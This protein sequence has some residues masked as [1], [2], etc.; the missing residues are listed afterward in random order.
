MAVIANVKNAVSLMRASKGQTMLTMFGIIVGIVSVVTIVSLGQGIRNQVIKQVQGT[1]KD[2]ITIRPGK[3]VSRN[4]DGSIAKINAVGSYGFGSGS[5]SASD[6]D[7]VAKNPQIEDSS[8]LGYQA[9]TL[10]TDDQTYDEGF[11]LGT[12]QS[13]P[14]LLNHKIAYGTYFTN[15]ESDRG[16]VVIGKTVA[17]QLF[18]E[19]VPVGRT[20]QIS[21]QEYIVRG[22]FEA[23]DTSPLNSQTDLNKAVF[24]PLKMAQAHSEGTLPIVQILARAKSGTS[25]DSAVSSLNQALVTAHHGQQDVTVLKQAENVQ[26]A[27]SLLDLFTNFII[28][29]AVIALVGGGVGIMN[30]MLLSVSERT[31][32]IG[33]RKA[34]GATN[35]QIRSQ[36]LTEASLLGLVGGVIGILLSLLANYII[37][38]T[39]E[40]RPAVSWQ[41]LVIAA[42]LAL[43][44]GIIFGMIP[45]IK[46][47][48]KDPIQALRRD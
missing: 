42:G 27:N 35:R 46:A 7:E 31:H 5:L 3:L 48:R 30:V 21:G 11:V 33:I 40:L 41:V 44:V 20:M 34:V 10:S 16:V 26:V 1:S 17:E 14:D 47:A 2:L 28:A 23:F 15:D 45:A 32:E 22:V 9:V 36:F 4:S 8:P 19:N 43:G 12:N 39:T 25:V 29:V 24:I 6:I 13:L 37:R 18:K 38:I